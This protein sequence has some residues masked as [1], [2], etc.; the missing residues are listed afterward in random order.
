MPRIDLK[1]IDTNRDHL[2]PGM[3]WCLSSHARPVKKVT[4]RQCCPAHTAGDIAYKQQFRDILGE[5][6][7]STKLE[8]EPFNGTGPAH[9]A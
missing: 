7:E 9:W 2:F 8:V 6:C 1:A 4:I 3:C 5:S